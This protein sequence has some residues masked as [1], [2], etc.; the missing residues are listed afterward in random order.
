MARIPTT[1]PV[2]GRPM[3][4]ACAS[5]LSKSCLVFVSQASIDA[6][7]VEKY[8]LRKQVEAV[9]NCRGISKKDMKLNDALP[10]ITVDPE[11]YD[12]ICDGILAAC[13][14]VNQLPLTQSVYL[15]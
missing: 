1:E 14:P 15:F 4:G 5:A 6:G 13:E 12:V 9:K 8:K 3:Y 10:A 7:N 2:I 11:T